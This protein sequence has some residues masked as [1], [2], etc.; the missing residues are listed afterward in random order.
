MARPKESSNKKD[1]QKRKALNRKEKEQ[2]KQDRKENN[3]KGK[4]L[5]EM[6]VYVDE[7]GRLSST[8]PDPTKKEAIN[9]EEIE[10]SVPRDREGPQDTTRKGI[11]S[12]F[13]ESKGYGFIRDSVTRESIFVHVNNLL[14]P[15]KENNK[16]TFEVER[17]PKG[18]T[19]VQVKL[20]K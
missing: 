14:E 7:F 9:A 12:F 5:E 6:F 16:V 2:R 1:L 17:G 13:N 4:S 19:A 20:D 10:I 3:S 15:V 11:L 8:P 18:Y